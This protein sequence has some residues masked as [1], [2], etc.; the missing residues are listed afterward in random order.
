MIEQRKGALSINQN[1]IAKERSTSSRVAEARLR[2]ACSIVGRT[3]L[4]A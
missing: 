2:G 4:T 3:V 1:A